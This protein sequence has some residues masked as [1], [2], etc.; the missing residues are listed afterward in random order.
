LRLRAIAQPRDQISNWICNSAHK[1]KI[2]PQR[3]FGRGR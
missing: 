3:P 2:A 1:F